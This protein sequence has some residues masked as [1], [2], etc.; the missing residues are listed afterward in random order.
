MKRYLVMMALCAVALLTSC[1]KGESLNDDDYVGGRDGAANSQAREYMMAIADDLVAGML[2]ELELALS[3]NERG[4][5]RSSHFTVGGP[6]TTPGSSWTV[7]AEDSPFYQLSIR[8]SGENTW[9]LD[10]SGDFALVSEENAYPTRVRMTASRYSHED[11]EGWTVTLDG[12]REER[13][14]YTCTFGTS[15]LQ[16]VNTRGA[17]ASGWNRMFGDLD[18]SVFKDGKEVDVCCLSFE[19]APSQAT[20]LRGL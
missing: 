14:G 10:Y 15:S 18:M 4:G 17:G 7:K 5:S 8:C 19:G 1:V 20:F 3:I 16:Y 12:S 13:L 11:G 6:L 2:D 9:D